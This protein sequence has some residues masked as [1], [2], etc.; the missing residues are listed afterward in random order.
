M[1]LAAAFR[2]VGETHGLP[3]FVPERRFCTDNGAMIAAAAELRGDLD[4]R[5]PLTLTA[6]PN[7]PFV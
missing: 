1:S 5:D 4:L 3:A 7:L 6:D 2:R